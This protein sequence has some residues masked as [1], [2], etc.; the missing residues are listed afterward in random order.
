[1]KFLRLSGLAGLLI[2]LTAS[3]ALSD[4][5][6]DAHDLYKQGKFAE[7]VVKYK[8]ASHEHPT[9]PG[10]WWNLGFSYR[11]LGK[12]QDALSSFQKASS[13]DPTHGFASKPGKY[14]EIIAS[15]KKALKASPKQPKAPSVK[16]DPLSK[17]P[18]VI[19]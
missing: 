6:A 10:I 14:E 2:L 13:L 16:P 11:K 8:Q 3:T 19:A 15:T 9:D 5:K 18:E 12:F 4:I 7:S 17:L 1:M